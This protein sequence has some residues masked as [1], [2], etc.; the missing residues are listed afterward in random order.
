MTEFCILEKPILVWNAFGA[1]FRI[2]TEIA[3]M[4]NL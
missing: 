3:E 4:K 1:K 2:I